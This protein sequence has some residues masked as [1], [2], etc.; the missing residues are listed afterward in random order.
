MNRL[1]IALLIFV[2]AFPLSAFSQWYVGATAGQYDLDAPNWEKSAMVSTRGGYKFS[3]VFSLEASY[4]FF[5]E[6]EQN[7]PP[8]Y[9]LEGGLFDVGLV[10]TIPL[11]KRFEIFGRVG[12]GYWA[13]DVNGSGYNSDDTG[14]SWNYGGGLAFNINKNFSVFTGYQKYEFDTEYDGTLKADTV[15]AGLKF[16]FDFSNGSSTGSTSYSAVSQSPQ[17]IPESTPP[18]R[19]VDAT[20]KSS[21]RF[22][23][24]VTAGSGGPGDPSIHTENAMRRALVA[25][26][27]AGADS[28]YVADIETTG[29]GASIILEALNCS[30]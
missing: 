16:F 17:P 4:V 19:A 20:E 27:D 12:Y 28:Y 9:T 15:Y 29:T 2:F 25:A 30:Q 23:K 18:L 6:T 10:G 21:C 22:V 7:S 3:D 14:D 8:Y 26:A 5:T 13:A 11:S 24:T 1:G